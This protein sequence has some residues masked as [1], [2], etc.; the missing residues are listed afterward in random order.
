[1]GHISVSQMVDVE[2]D[3]DYDDLDVDDLAEAL[4]SKTNWAAAI[5]KAVGTKQDKNVS[6]L[7]TDNYD[8]I[9]ELIQNFRLG[10]NIEPILSQ[11][12][13]NRYGLVC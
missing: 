10:K 2:I 3:V 9:K 12:A 1:M 4:I 8:E 7:A 13:Y 6:F 11:I 5:D